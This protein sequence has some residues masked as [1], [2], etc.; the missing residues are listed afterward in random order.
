MSL[1]SRWMRPV[2]DAFT[3]MVLLVLMCVVMCMVHVHVHVHVH[4]RLS[5]VC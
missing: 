1:Q 5:V 2:R 3:N 4:V